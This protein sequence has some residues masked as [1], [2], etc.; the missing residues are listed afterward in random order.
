MIYS[1]ARHECTLL[2]K[3]AKIFYLLAFC[4]GL[5]AFIFHWLL[6]EFYARTQ[7]SFLEP[8]TLV[9]LTEA[10]LHP[11]FA[12]TVLLFFFITPLLAANTLTQERKSDTLSLYLSAP[13]STVDLVMGKFMGAS[14]A[15]CFLLLPLLSITLLLGF[16]YR[17]DTGHLLASY[18][19]LLL[20]LG[21]MLSLSFL[22]A[23]FC[24]EPLMAIFLSF[25]LLL[26][27]SLLEWVGRFLDPALDYAEHFSLIY[28]CKNFLSGLVSTQDILYYV[29]AMI[30]CL[31]F[32]VLRLKHEAFFQG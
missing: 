11:L 26:A 14:L 30:L 5:I 29:I 19:G 17:L 32:T 12:W 23:S 28:H 4:Q 1:L 2:W 22:V 8:S 9:D 18:G 3:S 13:L 31:S 6:Q 21:A 16:E 25:S 10:V 27:F 7:R 24:T 20:C 15:H